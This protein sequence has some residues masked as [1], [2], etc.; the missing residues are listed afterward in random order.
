MTIP[1]LLSYPDVALLLLQ[2][3]VGGRFVLRK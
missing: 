3:T 2:F 1:Q